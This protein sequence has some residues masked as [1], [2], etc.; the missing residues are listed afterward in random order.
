MNIL[1]TFCSVI[2]YLSFILEA[3]FRWISFTLLTFTLLLGCLFIGK[4]MNL[5]IHL[6]DELLTQPLSNIYKQGRVKRS[7]FNVRAVAE[8]VLKIHVFC[9]LGH[10]L[11]VI[12]VEH[13]LDDHCT[14]QNPRIQGRSSGC[15]GG[16]ML[17]EKVDQIIPGYLSAQYYPSVVGS[18][19]L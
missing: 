18:S 12:Q 7:F 17:V 11:S 6:C 9:N 13:M 19:W 1:R 10:S 16:I 15:F 14:D 3:S 4:C 8:K 2:D 5:F